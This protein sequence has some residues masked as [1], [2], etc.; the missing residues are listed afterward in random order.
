MIARTVKA[1]LFFVILLHPQCWAGNAAA[2]DYIEHLRN[3]IT[4]IRAHLPAHTQSAEQAASEFLAGGNLWA[5]GR[6]ADFITEASQRA[7]GLM[8]I[9]HLAEHVPANHDVI[10]YATPGAVNDTDRKLFEEWR[11]K[12]ATV[13]TF[14]SPAGLFRN[15]F[16]VDTVINVAELWT[17][18]AEFVAACTR[19]GKMPVLY[20][21]YGLPGGY[22]RAKKYHGQRFHNDLNI[23][24]IAAGVLGADYINQLQRM[25]SQI[26]KTETA[27]MDRAAAW[28]RQAKSATALVTGH[29]FPIHSQDSRTI[30]ICDFVRAPAREDKELLGANPSEFIFYLGY[31]FAPQKLLNEAKLKR[32]KLV[33][34][35]VEPGQLAEPSD[36]ILYIAPAW[37]LADACVSV[38]GYDIPILPA[39]GVVQAAIYWTIASKSFGDGQRN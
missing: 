26:Q 15:K 19:S 7:G 3:T 4:Q 39:S 9:A 14:S 35:S 10:L 33:Y 8:S 25:L 12:G 29:M 2:E 32:M 18:T 17:W 38:P 28:W 21:S 34:S 36:N 27:K 5:A 11:A 23:S 30:H 13:I 22:D 37:P 31:Q 20:Q 24:P 16:P 6:Q 1:F